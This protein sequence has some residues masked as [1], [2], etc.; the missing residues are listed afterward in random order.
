MTLTE[1][2]MSSPTV[3]LR[4]I[5]S[6]A[7]PPLA[8]ATPLRVDDYAREIVASGLPAVRRFADRAIRLQLDGY[9][10]RIA[11]RDFEEA[12]HEVR[13]PAVLKR[14]MAAYAAAVS[15]TASL[16]KIRAA[17]AG[18][19]DDAPSRSTVSPYRDTLERLWIVD[20]VP[21]W[22]PTANNLSR[23]AAPD[24]HQLADPALAARLLGVNAEALLD[25]RPVGPALLRDGPLLGRLFESLVTLSVRVYAQPAE[26]TVKHLRTKGGEREVDL[27]VERFDRRIVAI[28][29]KMSRT[30]DDHDVRHLHWLRDQLGSDLLDALVVTMGDGVYRRKD[31]IGVVPAALLGP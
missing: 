22:L 28:E 12:G 19:R 26:G 24:K 9:L 23:L 6:G 3:S 11:E 1:R 10:D 18:G 4:E 14:W 5:M 21:A 27:I 2:G 13:K 7:R 29:V 25:A 8:G 20:P 16:E 30:V 15:T 31:G 17:A